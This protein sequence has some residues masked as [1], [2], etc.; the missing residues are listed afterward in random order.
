MSKSL[1]VRKRWPKDVNEQILA[2]YKE[3]P[4]WTNKE[5][6]ASFSELGV[7]VNKVTKVLRKHGGKM[8]NPEFRKR[9]AEIRS[10]THYSLY[11][12]I[13]TNLE[14]KIVELFNQGLPYP[15]ICSQ[16]NIENRLVVSIRDKHGLVRDKEVSRANIA[17]AST[18]YHD[19]T[20]S[21]LSSGRAAGATI[22][23]L[24]E[25]NGLTVSTVRYLCQ[26]NGVLLTSDQRSENAKKYPKEI[27]DKIKELRTTQHLELNEIAEIVGVKRSY[28][29]TLM[30][31]NGILLPEIDYAEVFRKS[32][33]D[34][35]YCL[36]SE[37]ERSNTKVMLKCS[38]GHEYWVIPQSFQGGARCRV[39]E[40]ASRKG[41]KNPAI[42]T[43]TFRDA[44]DACI[45]SNLVFLNCPPELDEKMHGAAN[46]DD[47]W[48]IK[49]HCGREF[50]PRIYDV[51]SRKL[52]SCGCIKSFA[53][54]EIERFLVGLGCNTVWNARGLLDGNFEIDVYVPELKIG[55]EY[56]GVYY[57]GELFSKED[58]RTASYKKWKMAKEKGIRLITIFESE[59]VFNRK[60]TEGFLESI[61]GI[62]DRIGA[63]KCEIKEVP[64]KDT[65]AFLEENHTHG[66]VR[67]RGT[68]LYYRDELVSLAVFK[69][70]ELRGDDDSTA[71]A[72]ELTRYCNKIGMS[73]SGGLPK[74]LTHFRAENPE[75]VVSFSDHRYSA[76]AMYK[77]NGFKEL[78]EVP[79]SYHYFQRGSQGPLFHKSNF[80]KEKIR[81]QFPDLDFPESLTE[82]E[83]MQLAGYDRIWD[84]GLTKWVLE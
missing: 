83:M 77:N 76:G 60:Q 2:K 75:P 40:N 17:A 80:R 78:G 18:K 55:I 41:R 70:S 21:K 30:Y 74:I 45:E 4:G 8:N 22:K 31:T 48:K 7:D 71:F 53:Q 58:A 14:S 73:V 34:S 43:L 32:V 28:I 69:S 25:S 51:I 44:Q 26:T 29:K 52:R 15:D 23:D 42:A 56:N 24:A 79:P 36:L 50:F 65:F 9:W 35:G 46:K 12:E 62:T 1:G 49:C 33:Q 20:I 82:W 61:F 39:C 3:S 6:A 57:H 68:G 38:L 66:G 16:L 72:W 37:Y 19:D 5:I 81:T 59:W 63:R 64:A 84:C 47:L 13:A 54:M 10:E 11:K 67:N 27:D